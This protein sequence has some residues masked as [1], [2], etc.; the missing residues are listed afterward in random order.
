MHQFCILN[1]R[2]GVDF[3]DFSPFCG[4]SHNSTNDHVEHLLKHV[5]GDLLWL[6]FIIF[7]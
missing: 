1:E 6:D 4:K 7:F 2:A 5:L 3:N